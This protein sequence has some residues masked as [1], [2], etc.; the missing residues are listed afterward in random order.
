MHD[1]EERDRGPFRVYL[2]QTFRVGS[3]L[4]EKTWAVPPPKVIWD[5]RSERL[6]GVRGRLDSRSA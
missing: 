4:Q 3:S 5:S 6:E 1:G 2:L